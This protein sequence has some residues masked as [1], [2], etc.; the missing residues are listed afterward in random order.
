MDEQIKMPSSLISTRHCPMTAT[1]VETT[2]LI[3]GWHEIVEVAFIVLDSDLEPT[4]D[5][6]HYKIRPQFEERITPKSM[7]IHGITLEELAKWP[8]ADIVL[9]IFNEWFE[10][11]ELPH[12]KKL[13]PLAHNWS[14]ESKFYEAWMG[15]ELMYK[16]F[17]LPRDSLRVATY[18]NDRACF[19][20]EQLPFPDNCQLGEVC[21]RLGITNLDPHSAFADSIATA[22]CYKQLLRRI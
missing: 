18:L 10:G 4:T 15:S 9:D 20:C 3:A 5:Y 11:L 14:Y 13:T 19:R 17:S 16:Y 1:D 2:G 6:F 7:Q 8:T 22:A 12:N 21:R